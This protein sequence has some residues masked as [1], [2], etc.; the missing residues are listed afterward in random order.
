MEHVNRL[1]STISEEVEILEKHEEMVGL[2]FGAGMDE[3]DPNCVD[4]N[5]GDDMMNDEEKGPILWC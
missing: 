5:G 1:D 2:G 3:Q 4:G